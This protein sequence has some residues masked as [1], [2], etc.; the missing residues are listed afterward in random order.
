MK[1]R[2]VLP[3]LGVVVPVVAALSAATAAVP[4]ARGLYT[5]GQA[6]EGAV[7]YAQQCAMCHGAALEGTFEVP[8]L[9]GKFVANWAGRPLGDLYG[10]LGRAMP[11]FAPGTLAPADNARIVAFLLKT[12]GY[13]AGATPLAAGSTQLTATL[14]A[15]PAPR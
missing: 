4:V 14:P 3:V 9:T 1:V 6:A 7:L 15:P 2:A 5:D 13:P 10:Y 12:N 11:Q 8:G